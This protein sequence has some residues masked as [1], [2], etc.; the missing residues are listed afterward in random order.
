MSMIVCDKCDAYI[1]AYPVA[2]HSVPCHITGIGKQETAMTKL[3]EVQKMTFDAARPYAVVAT[4]RSF[5]RIVGRYEN[6]AT[7][8][9][10]A[11]D[12]NQREG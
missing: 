3:Y 9:R 12:L 1:H 7:A 4:F 8:K 5:N 10:R 2:S 11:R 6:E